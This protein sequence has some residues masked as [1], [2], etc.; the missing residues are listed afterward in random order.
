MQNLNIQLC[1]DVSGNL[2]ARQISSSQ[3]ILR[4]LDVN[5]LKTLISIE[6]LLDN[7]SKFINS[8][9]V[10]KTNIYDEVFMGED[11]VIDF[12]SDGTFTYYKFIV[13]TL[14]YFL[15]KDNLSSDNTSHPL[16]NISAGSMFYYNNSLYFYEGGLKS[17]E[18]PS[19]NN[20]LKYSNNRTYGD[21]TKYEDM[22]LWSFQ[23][24]VFSFCNLQKCLLNLQAQILK[25][26]Y[27]CNGCGKSNGNN[28]DRYNRDF[29]L[30]ALYLIEYFSKIE[31]FDKAQYI[32][33]NLKDC[34]KQIC[35]NEFKLN[36]NCG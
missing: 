15:K 24:V 3:N 9:T 27:N 8:T 33:D 7:D 13:P 21:L 14:S 1:T 23:K 22:S 10:V 11:T 2:I 35:G 29:L 20:I 25:N 28:L 19:A 18:E 5:T 26:P 32:V 31:E 16:F 6:F 17:D 34:S 30:N 12:P 36:C 4:K